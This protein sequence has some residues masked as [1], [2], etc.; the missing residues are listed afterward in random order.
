MENLLIFLNENKEW[1]FSGLGTSLIGIIISFVLNKKN[2]TK[3]V[4]LI[5]GDVNVN[6]KNGS[7]AA[8]VLFIILTFAFLILIFIVN[9][10]TE[11]KIVDVIN[12]VDKD[13][14]TSESNSSSEEFNKTIEASY[15][16]DYIDGIYYVYDCDKKT[17]NKKHNPEEIG[18]IVASDVSSYT[19][20]YTDGNFLFYVKD[21]NEN[22]ALCRVDLNNLN[23]TILFQLSQEEI[24]Q[25]LYI[26]NGYIF[27]L[28]IQKEYLVLKRYEIATQSIE[29]V[30]EDVTQSIYFIDNILFFIRQNDDD[31]FISSLYCKDLDNNN[32]ELLLSEIK[33]IEQIE[34]KIYVSSKNQLLEI[35]GEKDINFI[36]DVENY[37]EISNNYLYEIDYDR[38]NVYRRKKGEEKTVIWKNNKFDSIYILE[39]NDFDNIYVLKDKTVYEIGIDS[40]RVVKS[41]EHLGFLIEAVVGDYAFFT[42]RDENSEFHTDYIKLR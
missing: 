41:N 11:N 26:Y 27:F 39:D 34:D 21:L 17:I 12:N 23:E 4:I 19:Y 2:E 18:I 8:T 36:C 29:L 28:T 25:P 24:I 1:L 40:N 16:A 10:C 32:E 22:Y 9:Y 30:T 7:S 33:S 38:C 6:L 31:P 13:V 35:N 5:K 3:N 15:I 42:Y 37:I 14:Q 20:F